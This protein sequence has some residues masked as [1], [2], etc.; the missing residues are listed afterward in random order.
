MGYGFSVGLGWEGRGNTWVCSILALIEVCWDRQGK[1]CSLG[2]KGNDVE[3]G[4]LRG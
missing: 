4:E 1:L 2:D 3:R